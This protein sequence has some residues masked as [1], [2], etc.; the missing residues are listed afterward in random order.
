[1]WQGSLPTE[2][3][4]GPIANKLVKKYNILFHYKTKRYQRML[5]YSCSQGRNRFN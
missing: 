4:Y 3:K 1:M 2:I 5:L